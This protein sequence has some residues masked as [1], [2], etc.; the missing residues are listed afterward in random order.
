VLSRRSDPRFG[1]TTYRLQN[2]VRA[3]PSPEL[4]QVPADYTV[5]AVPGFG[6]RTFQAKPF[7]AP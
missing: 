2:I 6:T 4:F 1:E 7:A 3:E 5:D